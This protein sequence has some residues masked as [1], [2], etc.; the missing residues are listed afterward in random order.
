MNIKKRIISVAAGTPLGEGV[1]G[2]ES[3]GPFGNIFNAGGS[4][5]G[6]GT[7]AINALAR[8]VSTIIG[9]MTIAAGIWFMINM[10]VAGLRWLQSEGDKHKL[11]EAQNRLTN[12]FIGLI[13]VGAGWSIL[14]LAGQFLGYDILLADPG[15]IIRSLGVLQ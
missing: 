8:I 12:G 11:E 6:Q 1:I 7:V 3:L 5:L 14:A 13:I 4:P 2:G 10:L 15:A 9:G